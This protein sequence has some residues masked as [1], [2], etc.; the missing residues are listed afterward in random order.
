MAPFPSF[1]WG[2]IFT[3]CA[4]YLVQYAAIHKRRC[5]SFPLSKEFFVGA[6]SL[7]L[8]QQLSQFL[9]VLHMQHT[10]SRPL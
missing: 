8:Q 1:I 10:S 7:V 5:A 3:A 6:T 9:H 4:V 2:M